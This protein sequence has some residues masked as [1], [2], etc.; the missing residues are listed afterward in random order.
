MR[1]RGRKESASL[2]VDHGGDFGRRARDVG[3]VAT[4][5]IGA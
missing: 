5:R 4:F 3:K 1:R 2:L